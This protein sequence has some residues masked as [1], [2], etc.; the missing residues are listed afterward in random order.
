LRYVNAFN[1]DY[2]FSFA[3]KTSGDTSDAMATRLDKADALHND[4]VFV[5][6]S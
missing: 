1:A 4:I 2:A 6:K 5:G 3:Y